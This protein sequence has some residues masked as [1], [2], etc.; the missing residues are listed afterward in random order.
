MGPCGEGW[1]NCPF[2]TRQRAEGVGDSGALGAKLKTL[3]ALETHP[4]Q[5]L[6]TTPAQERAGG[7]HGTSEP[8]LAKALLE[9][10]IHCV[11]ASS[12]SP[13]E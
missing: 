13:Q 5:R 6:A 4:R 8:T 1:V 10:R 9:N 3:A 11:H 12:S 2:S 7:S